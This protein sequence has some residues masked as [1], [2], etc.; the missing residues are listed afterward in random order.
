MYWLTQQVMSMNTDWDV[1][2]DSASDINELTE[3][4]SGYVE[5]CV[6]RAI[7]QKTIKMF[8]NDKPWITKRIKSIINRKKLAF[9]K[10]DKEK[11]R[12]VQ[13]EL[14]EEIRKE[15]EQYK[16]KVE[17]LFTCNNNYEKRVEWYEVDEQVCKW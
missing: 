17:S 6:E 15:K 10:N 5:F 16:Q 12:S 14:K 8:P 4:V 9:Q 7:P 1:F 3:S 13:K 11:Y 2:V